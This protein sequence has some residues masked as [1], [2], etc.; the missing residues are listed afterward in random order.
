MTCF[1]PRNVLVTLTE[2]F[3]E[4]HFPVHNLAIQTVIEC[5]TYQG[6]T[7]WHSKIFQIDYLLNVL[8]LA[9]IFTQQRQF[10]C[11]F[12]WQSQW[13]PCCGFV[14]AIIFSWIQ[15]DYWCFYDGKCSEIMHD[16]QMLYNKNWRDVQRKKLQTM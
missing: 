8:I 10:L 11:G 14:I 16:M 12:P 1:I 15:S 13:C 4:R 2:H 5:T 3:P 7:Y 9:Q 6:A